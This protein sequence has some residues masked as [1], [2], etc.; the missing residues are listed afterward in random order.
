MLDVPL[1]NRIIQ[2]FLILLAGFL[3]SCTK[4]EDYPVV[5]QLGYEDYAV[6]HG[7][8][9]LGNRQWRVTVRL[10]F[11]DG[12][13]DLGYYWLDDPNNSEYFSL[14]Y[15]I[16]YQKADT[17]TRFFYNTNA[18]GLADS[19]MRIPYIVPSVYHRAVKGWFEITFE[20]PIPMPP[21]PR[22]MPYDTLKYEFSVLDRAK[23]VSNT[24]ETPVIILS[25]IRPRPD[26]W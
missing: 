6:E 23:H 20:Y 7:S 16:Y 2:V 5:P 3:S 11:I 18:P 22:P 19:M 10:S 9:S 12:D 8:D 24:V 26:N 25:Q 13:G 1:N 14:K 21:N 15:K 4:E 17:F